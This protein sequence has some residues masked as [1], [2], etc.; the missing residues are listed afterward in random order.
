MSITRPGIGKPT[1]FGPSVLAYRG[2]V[3]MK[4]PASEPTADPALLAAAL[5]AD[6]LRHQLYAFIRAA[7]RPVTRDQAAT[8]AGISPKLAA[9]HLDKLARAGLLQ[10][11]TAVT[12]PSPAGGRPPRLYQPAGQDLQVSIPARQHDELAGILIDAVLT[13]APGEDTRAAALR[14]AR[15]R[16]TA[17]GATTRGRRRGPERA[18]ATT[19]AALRQWGFEPERIAPGCLRLRN[20]PFHPLAAQAPGLV[21]AINHAFMTGFLHGLDTSAVQ[22][23]LNPQASGCCVE[24]RAAEVTQYASG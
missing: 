10:V 15:A 1:W 23:V 14:A 6:G 13:Q 12:G 18:L 4:P 7:G 8:A 17:L 21:C 2:R 24:L 16:G 19:Q 3:T 9:F 20:C 5:L 22:A 11:S